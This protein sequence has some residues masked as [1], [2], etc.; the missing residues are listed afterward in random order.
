[1]EINA[2]STLQNATHENLTRE[3]TIT[4]WPKWPVSRA[5]NM[6]QKNL[7]TEIEKKILHWK[8]YTKDFRISKYFYYSP[9]KRIWQI[10]YQK[11]QYT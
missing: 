7:N 3:L 8:W 2:Q 4:S 11:Q 6:E 1:M 5:N 9:K 10:V